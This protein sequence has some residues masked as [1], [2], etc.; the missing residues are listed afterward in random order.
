MQYW[1]DEE[2]VDIQHAWIKH[3]QEQTNRF[4]QERD[5]QQFKLEILA[6]CRKMIEE[7]VPKKIELAVK[8]NA[9]PKLREIDQT[10]KNLGHL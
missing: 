3:R 6:E 4:N 5:R 1:T 7:Q 9:T 10:I 2:A 8:D